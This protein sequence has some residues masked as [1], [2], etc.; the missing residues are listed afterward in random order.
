M[1][2]PS[3]VPHSRPR[4]RRSR[5]A[6]AGA[7]RLA[8]VSE[9]SPRLG[10]KDATR[11]AEPATSTGGGPLSLSDVVERLLVEFEPQ[12]PLPAIYA[13]VRR[14][15]RELDT[16]PN[17]ARPELVE[18]LARQRLGTLASGTSATPT[19]DDAPRSH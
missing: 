17:P 3:P 18:R 4:A 6:S 14:C 1:T 9:P 10:P 15:R 8:N 19:G 12:L 2:D 13:I 5:Q 16:Q 7:G 11:L